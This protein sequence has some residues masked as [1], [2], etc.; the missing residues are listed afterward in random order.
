MGL[1]GERREERTPAEW[2]AEAMRWYVQGHQACAFCQGQHCVFRSA[3]G[4]RVEY[5]CTSCDFSVCQDS[6]TGRAYATPGGAAQPPAALL[7]AE[8]LWEARSSG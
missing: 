7:P 5:H 8:K 4:S 2:F 3:Y 6:A 1:E